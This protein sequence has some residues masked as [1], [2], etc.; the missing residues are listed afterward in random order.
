MRLTDHAEGKRIEFHALRPSSVKMLHKARHWT[1][2]V[3]YVEDELPEHP[4]AHADGNGDYSKQAHIKRRITGLNAPSW[5]DV[6]GPGVYQL[7]PQTES[8]HDNR[9]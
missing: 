4:T 6:P 8:P 2:A 3:E 7:A 1:K 5:S 9:V